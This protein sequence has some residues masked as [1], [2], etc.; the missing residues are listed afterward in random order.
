[1]IKQ[2][3]IPP[4]VNRDAPS[5]RGGFFVVKFCFRQVL[6]S[7]SKFRFV[8]RAV[9]AQHAFTCIPW[10]PSSAGVHTNITA[11]LP[12]RTYSGSGVLYSCEQRN[13]YRND[14]EVTVPYHHHHDATLP[15]DRGLTGVFLFSY[16]CPRC[17]VGVRYKRC[18]VGVR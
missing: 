6:R 17:S 1:L 5:F 4:T 12:R 15:V 2:T 13:R 10:Q 8:F 7:R 11:T 16:R 3:T 9:F 14:T 18:N